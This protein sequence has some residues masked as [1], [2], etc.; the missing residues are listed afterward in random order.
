M[1]LSEAADIAFKPVLT[2][3]AFFSNWTHHLRVASATQFKLQEYVLYISFILLSHRSHLTL[4]QNFTA[5][6]KRRAGLSSWSQWALKTASRSLWTL[7]VNVAVSSPLNRLARPATMAMERW[8]VACA[9]VIQADW[10][11][12]ASAPRANITLANKT[13]VAPTQRHR[14]VADAETACAA[15]VPVARVILGRFGGRTVNATTSAASVRK[16]SCVQVR[17]NTMALTH[18]ICKK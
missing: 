1:L 14:P 7:L 16:D 12:D 2:V 8:S 13:T 15:S 9:C 18:C 3:N 6:Q 11:L 4:R 17:L 10:A 5:V